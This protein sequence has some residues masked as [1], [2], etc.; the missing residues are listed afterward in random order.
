MLDDLKRLAR[1]WRPLTQHWKCSFIELGMEDAVQ[2]LKHICSGFSSFVLWQF[3][4]IP[5]PI[6]SNHVNQMHVKETH[7]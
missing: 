3:L 6:C 7:E 5:V 4:A 2:Y 1:S